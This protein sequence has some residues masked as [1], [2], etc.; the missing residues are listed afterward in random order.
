MHDYLMGQ[1]ARDRRTELHR[2]A[3]QARLAGITRRRARSTV[4]TRSHRIGTVR[5]HLRLLL[6]R[7]AI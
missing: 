1:L 6:G 2:E 5:T 7:A 3:A 4:A